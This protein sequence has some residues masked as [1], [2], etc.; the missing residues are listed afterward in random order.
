MIHCTVAFHYVLYSVILIL[1]TRG[2]LISID[3]SLHHRFTGHVIDLMY[4]VARFE[5]CSRYH[6]VF[7][8]LQG[9]NTLV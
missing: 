6:F 5:H 1:A 2:G 3:R 4:F 7:A 8:V 9:L